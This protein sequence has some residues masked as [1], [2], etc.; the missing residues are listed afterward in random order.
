MQL[1][2]AA[3]V[4]TPDHLVD[5]RGAHARQVGDWKKQELAGLS[6]IFTNGREHLR[7]QADA[8]KD[9]I[10]KQI[11]QLSRVGLSQKRSW[12]CPMVIN[13]CAAIEPYEGIRDAPAA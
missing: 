3:T 2:D 6:G 4:A 11:G 12:P 10:Y 8:E 5:A 13:C 1:L 9:E 7:Q